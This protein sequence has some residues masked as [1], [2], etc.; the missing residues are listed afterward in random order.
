MLPFIS[1]GVRTR[2]LYLVSPRV[3]SWPE[4][5]FPFISRGVRTQSL[6]M[7]SPCVKSWPGRFV[8]L[9]IKRWSNT[10]LERVMI[11]AVDFDDPK[12][13]ILDQ[14]FNAGL[15]PF[16]FE[17]ILGHQVI[18]LIYIIWLFWRKTYESHL[19]WVS[20][21]SGLWVSGF[22][23]SLWWEVFHTVFYKLCWGA[24]MF[25]WTL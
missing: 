13:I 8:S 18:F 23:L 21:L 4:D 10:E 22:I 5:L 12:V 2:S 11:L 9:Y 7:A 19:K 1:H 6:N 15:M 25:E 17:I 20:E 14:A 16:R 3:L 24:Y